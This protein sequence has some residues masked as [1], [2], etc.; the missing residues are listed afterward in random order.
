MADYELVAG[1]VLPFAMS[2]SCQREFS[3]RGFETPSPQAP[4]T[5]E[6]RENMKKVSGLSF[7]SPQ[8]W[9]EWRDLTSK[10]WMFAKD[11]NFARTAMK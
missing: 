11:N 6:T 3:V 1:T 7:K 4:D 2:G 9:K 10:G 8:K 5:D